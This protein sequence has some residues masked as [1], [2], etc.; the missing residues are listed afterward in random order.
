MIEENTQSS[1]SFISDKKQPYLYLKV[2]LTIENEDASQLS[3][4][5]YKFLIM[6]ALKETLG[7]VGASTTVDL[8]KLSSDAVALLRLPSRNAEK[9]WGALTLYGTT[10]A[11]RRCAFRVLQVSPFLMGLAFDT[12]RSR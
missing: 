1:K 5:Q 4:V 8:L 12:R 3:P 2:L 7:Q 10:P 6:Q 11:K 9:V